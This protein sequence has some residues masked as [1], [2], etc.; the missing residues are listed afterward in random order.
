MLA[1]YALL[2]VMRRFMEPYGIQVTSPDISLAAR[3]LSQWKDKLSVERQKPDAL[4]MLG[5]LCQYEEANIIKLPNISASIPQLNAVITELQA[6][7]YPLPDFPQVPITDAEKDAHARYSKA[8]GS[9]VNPVLREG[10]SDRRVAGPVKKQAQ[11]SK[12]PVRMRE[13]PSDSSTKVCTHFDFSLA[14]IFWLI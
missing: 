9:A 1:T 4:K 3:I 12:P 5:D 13:W 7:G 14:E 2:P 6:K 11:R 8:L 10:N